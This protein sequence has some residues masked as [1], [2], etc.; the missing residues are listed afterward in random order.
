M[1]DVGACQGTPQSISDRV[2]LDHALP[3]TTCCTLSRSAFVP[4]HCPSAHSK[5]LV[6]TV[7]TI[8]TMIIA[9]RL[10]HASS[11]VRPLT[12]TFQH[13]LTEWPP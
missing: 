2:R 10:C 6:V 9:P 7:A 11:C 3:T 4:K 8:S 12:E 13:N 5:R 1:F